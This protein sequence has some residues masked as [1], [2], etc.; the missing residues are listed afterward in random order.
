[1]KDPRW[2]DKARRLLPNLVFGQSLWVEGNIFIDDLRLTERGWLELLPALKVPVLTF[3]AEELTQALARFVE[4]ADFEM[5]IFPGEGGKVIQTF[6]GW[7]PGLHVPAR[8]IG[9]RE[10]KAEVAGFTVSTRKVLVID[11]VVA[12]GVTAA[13]IY[14]QGNLSADSQLATWLMDSPRDGR[15][16][17]FRKVC[18]GL[19][20][21]G[22][23]RV[24][25]NT[26]STFLRYPER[27][28][29]YAKRYARD[30][31]EFVEFFG[32]IKEQADEGR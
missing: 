3:T 10:P 32:L 27:L 12:T 13:E 15:L 18:T 17:V 26:L 20:I 14:R 8:R 31:E 5:V 4:A 25:K 28:E 21:G 19:L 1:M 2:I 9:L 24:S 30:P 16:S 29:D 11:D 23:R 7:E 22:R 6:L